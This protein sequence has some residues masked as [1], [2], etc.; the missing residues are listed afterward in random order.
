MVRGKGSVSFSINSIPYF[1]CTSQ[2][3]HTFGWGL[4]DIRIMLIMKSL[5]LAS[6]LKKKRLPLFIFNYL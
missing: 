1:P 2:P 3:F 6:F 5:L 4:I